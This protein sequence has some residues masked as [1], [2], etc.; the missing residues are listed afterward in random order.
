[1]MSGKFTDP[2]LTVADRLRWLSLL[3]KPQSGP[4][5]GPLTA[6]QRKAFRK[7]LGVPDTSYSVDHRRAMFINSRAGFKIIKE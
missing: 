5:A 6:Q 4:S 3:E 2:V 1:M 7:L